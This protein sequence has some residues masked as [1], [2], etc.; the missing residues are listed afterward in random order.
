VLSTRDDIDYRG[1][2]G[3]LDLDEN[4]DIAEPRFALYGFSPENT[5][6]IAD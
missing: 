6:V 5:L 2:T 3:P 1:L 4:G